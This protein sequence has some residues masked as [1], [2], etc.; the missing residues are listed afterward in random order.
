MQVNYE[1]VRIV[2]ETIL[3]IGVFALGLAS[4][5]LLAVVVLGW[6]RRR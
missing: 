1:A 3:Y 6:R 5:T 4:L 2:R